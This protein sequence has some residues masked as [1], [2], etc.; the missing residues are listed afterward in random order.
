MMK[1]N[2]RARARLERRVHRQREPI[3]PARRGGRPIKGRR[4]TAT[5]HAWHMGERN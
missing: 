1:N 3:V 4:R 2:I 5:V